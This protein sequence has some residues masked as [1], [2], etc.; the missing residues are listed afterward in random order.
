MQAARR[1]VRRYRPGAWVG[2]I[3]LAL[4]ATVE[5]RGEVEESRPP[6]YLVALWEPPG[7]L[8]RPAD[9]SSE[10]APECRPLLPRW[11]AVAAIAAPDASGA[12]LELMRHVPGDA[13][14]WLT[15]EAI[16]WRLVATI[17]LESDRHL[18]PYHRDGLTA[19]IASCDAADR[20]Q[21]RAQY[22]DRDAGYERW[23]ERLL[24]SSASPPAG[25]GSAGGRGRDTQD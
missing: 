12:L 23:R 1:L 18:E 9:A 16:D 4:D 20:E 25:T 15:D 2:A 24:P 7:W 21:I 22:S 5:T 10:Q 19:F 13:C 14:V 17:V 6:H 8:A 3:R 11:P